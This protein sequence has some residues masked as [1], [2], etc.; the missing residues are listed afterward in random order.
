MRPVVT[1]SDWRGRNAGEALVMAEIE[2]GLRAVVGHIDLAMLIGRHRPRID[3][4]IGIE[5][6]D[7]DLVAARLEERPEGGREKTFAKR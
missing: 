2:V 7:A 3:V 4:E 5:L 1:L 6:P